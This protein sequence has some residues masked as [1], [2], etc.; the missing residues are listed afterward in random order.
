M[1]D[2]K[3]SWCLKQKNGMELVESNDNLSKAYFEEFEETLMENIKDAKKLGINHQ[4]ALN[5]LNKL[6]KDKIMNFIIQGR[7]KKYMFNVNSLLCKLYLQ[8]AESMAAI[9]I[10]DNF[11]LKK[12]IETI[13]PHSNSLIIFGSFAKCMEKKN[14]NLDLIGINVANK[15]DLKKNH[16]IYGNIYKVVDLYCG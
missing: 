2:K 6:I 7:N 9:D 15:E 12:I 3:I 10:L 5:Y 13:F 1:K 16:I 14:Q 4:T 8:M 11:E